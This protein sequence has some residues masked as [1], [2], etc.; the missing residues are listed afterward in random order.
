MSRA[1]FDNLRTG[2][3][4]AVR[5]GPFEYGDLLDTACCRVR[6][7][8]R[9]VPT[10]SC[11]LPPWPMLARALLIPTLLPHEWTTARSIFSMRCERLMSPDLSS[12]R[13]ARPMASRILSL[14]RDDAA[15]SGKPY[16]RSKLMVEHILADVCAAHGLGATALRYFNG[17]EANPDWEI[18]EDH[19]PETH[20][21][22][23]VLQAA[24]GLQP[25]IRVFGHDWPTPDGTCIRR[26]DPRL[27]P[28]RSARC[29]GDP[30]GAWPFAG[31]QPWCWKGSSIRE[32]IETAR[33]ATGRT[34][35]EEAA[36]RRAGDP[37]ELVADAT[38]AR[39]ALNWSPKRL[40]RA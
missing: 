1:T 26:H 6:F 29:C 21:I 17:G 25:E 16:G 36:P 14:S 37:P 35:V 24:A 28:C 9:G 22:P 30:H 33:R 2:H 34:I 38:A 15:T 7:A 12:P 19:D 11:I 10:L 3:R 31:L 8:R 27:R 23:L 4:R 20:L 40:A 5:W 32:V 39:A 18:G 13:P